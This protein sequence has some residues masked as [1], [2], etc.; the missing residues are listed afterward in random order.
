MIFA[1]PV[2]S[3]DQLMAISAP[4]PSSST[5]DSS[6]QTDE[7]PNDL[8]MLDLGLDPSDPLNLLL[9]N[10]SQTTQ[11]STQDISSQ[12]GIPPDWSDFS[13]LWPTPDRSSRENVKYPEMP[14][15]FSPLD[16]DYNP[17][18]AVD[19]S[20][21]HLESTYPQ[22]PFYSPTG[23]L[24]NELLTASFPFTFGS[25]EFCG[26]YGDKK[27]RRLSMTSSS[28]SSGASLSPVIEPLNT[29]VP[30]V[31]N[32]SDE[33]AQRVR[34]SVGVMLAVPTGLSGRQNPLTSALFVFVITKHSYLNRVPDTV[35]PQTQAKLP[36]P[37]LPRSK[38]AT[39]A[40]R[41]PPPKSESSSTAST[42]PPSDSHTGSPMSSPPSEPVAQTAG[43]TVGRPKTNHTTIERRYRTNLNARIQSL[44][45]AVPA[46]RVLEEKDK[47]RKGGDV[48]VMDIVDDRGFVDGVKVARK[49]S[50]ANVL[51]K[52]VEY[53]RFV[54]V[55]IAG[56]VRVG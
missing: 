1:F 44:R 56:L 8:P 51:G 30:F 16:L 10:T 15:E 24:S 54:D 37:R 20:A 39:K 5:S 45:Q 18:M 34:Q 26:P 46:L 47:Q 36:I 27:T 38:V 50:K 21:L 41:I 53:I 42:P 43:Q 17:S 33:L 9:H 6:F 40:K 4:S 3:N 28:S 23:T 32:P 14:I 31:G 2:L 7:Y 29:T 22:P 11:D 49:C 52:A 48:D 55:I 19:P 25:H 35:H 13:I 12:H